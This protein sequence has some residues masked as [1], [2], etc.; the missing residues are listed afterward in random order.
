MGAWSL[1]DS[2]L[3][4]YII[5]GWQPTISGTGTLGKN[6]SMCQNLSTTSCKHMN[7]PILVE[8]AILHISANKQ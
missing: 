3:L 8:H 2:R 1:W 4:E 5:H 6:T 7:T